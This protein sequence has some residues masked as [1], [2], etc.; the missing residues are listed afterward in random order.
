[1]DQRLTKKV[2]IITGAG[3]TD[4]G[5][6]VGSAISITF[7][8]HGCKV[9]LVDKNQEYAE[10]T[11][12]AIRDVG[13]ESVV[14]NADV[15]KISDAE[16][17]VDLAISSFGRL[18][19]LVN[20]VGILGIGDVTNV[21]EE[22]WDNVLDTNLKSMMLTSKYAIPKMTHTGGGSIINMSSVSGLRGSGQFDSIPYSTSKGAVVTLTQ[23][24]AVQ[25]GRDNIRVNAIAPGLI[26]TPMV[27]GK[28]TTEQRDLRTRAA[29]LGT[30]GTAW[31]I[32]LASLF[33]A[34][35]ESR[36]ITGVV[37]PVD[38]G[39]ITTTPLSGLHYH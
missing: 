28:M 16:K 10:N 7:A 23:T 38:A 35:E 25:H 6:G 3:S 36:W 34:S 8:K 30:E 15:T 4:R 5:D 32:A 26:Y 17:M 22:N 2:A 37:L 18:D 14:C 13:G 9:L 12:S 27:S 24:M 11:A 20:N 31:D 21:E 39:L 1:M 19:I 33:L 29:P